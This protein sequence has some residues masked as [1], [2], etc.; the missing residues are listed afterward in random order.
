MLGHF[1]LLV[2]YILFLN[3][4]WVEIRQTMH[5]VIMRKERNGMTPR[6]KVFVLGNNSHIMNM[7][8]CLVYSWAYG[9]L[10]V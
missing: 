5:K 1:G 10:Y 8:D 6:V 3:I 4:F 2:K 9:R 7:H